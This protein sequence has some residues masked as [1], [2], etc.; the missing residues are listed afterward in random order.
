ML[1]FVSINLYRVSVC[2]DFRQINVGI[3]MNFEGTWLA[4]SV[5]AVTL[6]GEEGLPTRLQSFE[7]F[8]NINI[9]R[10][11]CYVFCI[12]VLTYQKYQKYKSV[13]LGD[14]LH[15]YLPLI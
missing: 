1:I 14:Q 6:L 11:P 13:E 15:Q 5:L 7:T 3:L 8:V 9:S 12:C 2:V 4:K 10:S